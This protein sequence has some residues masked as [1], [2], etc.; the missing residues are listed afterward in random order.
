MKNTVKLIRHSIVVMLL[1]TVLIILFNII[2]LSFVMTP[3]ISFDSPWK[4][5]DSMAAQVQKTDAAPFLPPDLAEKLEN[6]NIWAIIIDKNSLQ[7]IWHTDNLPKEIPA[8]YSLGDIAD[9]N[10]G[11]IENY[12]TFSSEVPDGLLVLGYPQKSFWKLVHPCWSY[13]FIADSPKILLLTIVLNLALLLLLYILINSRLMKSVKP[14]AEGILQLPCGVTKPVNENGLLSD[15]AV[16]I[17]KTSAILQGQ[18]N[19]L[20]RKDT[21]RANWIAGISHD[22]RTPLSMIMGYTSLIESS[23]QLDDD[24]QKKS[25]AIIRQSEKIKNLISD[26]NLVSKLEYNMQPVHQEELNMPS[27]IRQITVDF[28]NVDVEGKYPIELMLGEDTAPCLVLGDKALL[29]RALTN[30]VQNC[31]NHNDA[32]CSIYIS[33]EKTVGECAILVED[34]G[35]SVTDSKLDAL[36]NTPHYLV[37]DTNTAK[38]RHGLGLLIV[39]QI[40]DAHHGETLICHSR[41]G[42]FAVKL[43]LPRIQPD[44]ASNDPPASENII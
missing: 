16:N 32:G 4:N 7:T 2:L 36:N 14:V 11:Y 22:I 12:P 34:D 26:L 39:R 3:Y 9:F 28:L 29:K 40:M 19:Q 5:A 23:G 31:I 25:S 15:L 1:G 20:K 38:Q 21:A 6:K 43:T 8:G 13:K 30:L 10:T 44:S 18:K 37:C 17:N 24:L 41:Y 35:H 27:I 42:G 33:L